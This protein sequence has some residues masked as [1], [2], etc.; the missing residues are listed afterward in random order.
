MNYKLLK[1]G[2]LTL[3]AFILLL[4]FGTIIF[5][6]KVL[7]VISTQTMIIISACLCLP[8]FVLKFLHEQ[9]Y[10]PT[11]RDKIIGIVLACILMILIFS[12]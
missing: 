4:S 2:Y 11:R 8:F 12:V 7:E 10:P 6:D 1:I 3:A 5:I 9:K